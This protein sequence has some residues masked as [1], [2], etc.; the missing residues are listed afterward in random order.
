M[1]LTPNHLLTV[2]SNMHDT[3]C[4][5]E[6]AHR[7]KEVRVVNVKLENTRPVSSRS[8]PALVSTPRR[9]ASQNPERAS[10]LSRAICRCCT[11]SNIKIV[12]RHVCGLQKLRRKLFSYQPGPD[13]FMISHATAI[14]SSHC[15]THTRNEA[16][17]AHASQRR[18]PSL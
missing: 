16:F 17:A 1:P 14:S 7:C 12:L 18:V 9:S 15:L 3:N 11:Y 6:P 5:W 4:A 10:M 8:P 13:S 2:N